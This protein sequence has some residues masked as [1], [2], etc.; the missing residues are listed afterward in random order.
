LLKAADRFMKAGEIDNALVEIDKTIELDPQNFYA[1]A[2]KE[3][4]KNIQKKGGRAGAETPAA[5]P[6]PADGKAAAETN[7]GKQAAAPAPAQEKQAPQQPAPQPAQ[8]KQ[9][10]AT[11]VSDFMK[12]RAE[13]AKLREAEGK[14]APAPKQTP[15]EAQIALEERQ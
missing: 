1:R 8:A 12:R 10:P 11:Q 5:A 6:V 3:R 9:A 14:S 4:L 2:Y 13:E 15:E 7:G